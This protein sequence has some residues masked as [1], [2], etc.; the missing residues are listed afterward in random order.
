[1]PKCFISAPAGTDLATLRKALSARKVSWSD[2]SKLSLG[3]PLRAQLLT[4]IAEADFVC[5]VVLPGPRS[6]AVFYEMGAASASGKPVLAFVSPKADLPQFTEDLSYARAD[7]DDVQAVA[8]HLDAFLRFRLKDEPP[9]TRSTNRGRSVE[10]STAWLQEAK[11]ALA[12]EDWHHFE[13][14]FYSLFHGAGFAV[15]RPTDKKG[16]ADLALWLDSLDSSLDP[17]LVEVKGGDISEE[18][19]RIAEEQ[20]RQHVLATGGQIG[21]LLYLDREGKE[22]P[23]S[24]TTFPLV[25]RMSGRELL[26]SVAAGRFEQELM[27]LRNLA[28]HGSE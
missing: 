23:G 8:L 14:C 15:N 3:T 22:F 18:R 25:L 24:P 26:D 2:Q 17:L 27:R 19:L 10:A 4:L 6:N 16:A 20:L 13:D 5:A 12:T 7:L 1:M 9:K 11:Q 28:V 21:L